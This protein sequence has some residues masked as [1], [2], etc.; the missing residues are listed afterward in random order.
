MSVYARASL[1][2]ELVRTFLSS[3]FSSSSSVLELCVMQASSLQRATRGR[4]PGNVASRCR[5]FRP[6]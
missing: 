2:T 4:P 1:V 6:L 3:R 5:L